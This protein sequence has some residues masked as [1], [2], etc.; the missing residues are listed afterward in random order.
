MVSFR[1]DISCILQ[2]RFETTKHLQIY[3]TPNNFLTT[4]DASFSVKVA[5]QL[6]LTCYGPIHTSLSCCFCASTSDN[7]T[8][9]VYIQLHY[10]PMDHFTTKG[11]SF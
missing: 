5:K 9:S 7:K 8:H 2:A 11:E 6:Q 3:Y 1:F 4:N 10:I